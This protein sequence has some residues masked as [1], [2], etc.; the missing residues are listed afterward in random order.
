[1]NLISRVTQG[2]IHKKKKI[3]VIK[4]LHKNAFLLD[5]LKDI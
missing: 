5:S 3:V 1:M 2:D 4:L